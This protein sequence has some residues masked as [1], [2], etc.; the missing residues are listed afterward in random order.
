MT[1]RN[2]VITYV[3]STTDVIQSFRCGRIRE[4]RE[5]NFVSR[6]NWRILNF[7]SKNWAGVLQRFCR[8]CQSKVCACF[9]FNLRLEMD[10]LGLVYRGGKLVWS[11]NSCR[12]D[13]ILV[14]R[15][16]ARVGGFFL[17]LRMRRSV[18]FVCR[19]S[20]VLFK[21]ILGWFCY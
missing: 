15:F 16:L 2:F 3:S 19:C 13:F 18:I 14:R 6:I 10:C 20:Y 5:F 4:G 8:C 7:G 1:G 17:C 12:K 9:L 11:G 21:S